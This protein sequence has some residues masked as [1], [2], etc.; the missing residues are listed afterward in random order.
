MRVSVELPDPPSLDRLLEGISQQYEQVVRQLV[1]LTEQAQRTD[2][3]QPV[4]TA[5]QQ[6]QDQLIAAFGQMLH[7]IQTS[8]QADQNHL[9][10][11]IRQ[12]V[13]APQHEASQ[14]LIQAIRGMKRS[15]ASL[16]DDLGNVMNKQ[17]KIRQI[18][19]MKESPKVK[20]STDSS[21]V[22]KKLDQMESALVRAMGKSRNRTFGS[23]Y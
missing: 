17:M 9:Q 12:E 19:I 3:L 21:S 15:V 20:S 2:H 4:V 16:P 23:N 18:E 13:A 8:K 1:H 10:H 11:V 7:V 6:Q 14:A 5:L 22:V